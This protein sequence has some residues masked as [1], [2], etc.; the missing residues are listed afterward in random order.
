MKK[1]IEFSI[2]ST[3]PLPADIKFYVPYQTKR[4]YPCLGTFCSQREHQANCVLV[5]HY[6]YT[7]AFLKPESLSVCMNQY[8]GHECMAQVVPNTRIMYIKSV[9][10]LERCYC[11]CVGLSMSWSRSHGSFM[12]V[13]Y[14]TCRARKPVCLA[15]LM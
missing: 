10:T 13:C 1:K 3:C 4:A 5:M 12:E 6:T 2:I 14:I 11:T 7:Y 15:L 9:L 8:I